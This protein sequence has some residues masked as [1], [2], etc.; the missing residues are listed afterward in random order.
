MMKVIYE[1]MD[2]LDLPIDEV[3]IDRCHRTGAAYTDEHTVLKSINIF[4]RSLH[5]W[6]KS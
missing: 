1:E 5:A 4:T 2:K 3:E 6:I